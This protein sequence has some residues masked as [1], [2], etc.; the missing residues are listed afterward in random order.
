MRTEALAP[1]ADTVTPNL[2]DHPVLAGGLTI[3]P[4]SAPGVV[5]TDNAGLINSTNGTVGQ[6]IVARGAGPQWAD[7]VSADSSVIFSAAPGGGINLQAVGGGGGGVTKLEGDDTLTVTPDIVTG[8][9]KVIGDDTIKTFR[10]ALDTLTVGIEDSPNNGDIMIGGG[11]HVPTVWA[12]L[13]SSGG[14]VTITNPGPNQINLEAAGIAALTGLSA[15]AGVAAPLAGIINIHGAGGLTTSAAGNVV[16]VDAGAPDLDGRLLVSTAG[17]PATWRTLTAGANITIQ[18]LNDGAG[19]IVISAS[20]SGGTGGVQQLDCDSG[21]AVNPITNIMRIEGY[22]GTYN[23]SHVTHPYRNI[24]TS[25]T[26][27]DLVNLRMTS[28]I[29]LPLTNTG[30]TAGVIMIGTNDFMHAYGTDNTFLGDSA[31]NRTLT[32]AN[33]TANT[34]VGAHA[35]RFIKKASNNVIIGT[36][37]LYALENPVSDLYSVHNVVI[38]SQAANLLITAKESV[39]IGYNVCGNATSVNSSIVIGNNTAAGGAIDHDII[40]GEQPVNRA[41]PGPQQQNTCLIA[42]IFET[43]NNNLPATVVVA[44]KTGKLTRP[45]GNSTKGMVL[46]EGGRSDELSYT[47]NPRWGSVR[48][49]DNSID[50]DLSN[51]GYIDIRTKA[52][53]VFS[54]YQRIDELYVSGDGT[55]FWLGTRTAGG[56]FPG[57]PTSWVVDIDPAGSFTN[58]HWPYHDPIRYTA[59][60]HGFY[61]FNLWIR[62]SVAVSTPPVCPIWFYIYKSTGILYRKYEY[63][64]PYPSGVTLPQ[65]FTTGY[66]VYVVMDVG[67]YLMVSYAETVSPPA[68]VVSVLGGIN[69]NLSGFMLAAI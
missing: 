12:T 45:K 64:Q 62:W 11:P 49:P 6:I 22:D 43:P 55:E 5:T 65:I 15:D 48:S 28:S 46:M 38:G 30:G 60:Y 63:A 56:S 68:K 39:L 25:S 40:I 29:Q 26:G 41:A 20:G 24:F 19:Q 23:S 21:V 16:T 17:G 7:L 10:S 69:T 14:S 44:D 52:N 27:N 9:I 53:Q 50:V 47:G 37:A 42:G 35:G 31:G 3:T 54:A 61:C 32:T 36:H 13:T 1:N 58:S 67:D 57:D 4:L 59:P 8:I 33:A 66:S 51:I 34:C 2:V 18:Q